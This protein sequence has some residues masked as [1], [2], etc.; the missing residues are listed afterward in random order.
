MNLHNHSWS[1][2]KTKKKPPKSYNGIHSAP[3]FVIFA[4]ILCW[5][6][7]NAL[8]DDQDVSDAEDDKGKRGDVDRKEATDLGGDKRDTILNPYSDELSNKSLHYRFAPQQ[9]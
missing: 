7:H 6:L 8:R 1:K 4:L 3:L 5:P 2:T 9:N